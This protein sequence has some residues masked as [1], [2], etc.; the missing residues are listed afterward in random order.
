MLADEWEAADRTAMVGTAIVIAGNRG[1][2]VREQLLDLE[3]LTTSLAH[4]GAALHA[5]LPYTAGFVAFAQGRLAETRVLLHESADL[6]LANLPMSAP[7][8]A[9]AAIWE[10]NASGAREDLASLD[11]AGLHG[12]AV[13][14]DRM[15]IRAGIAALEGRTS[16]ALALYREALSAERELGLLWDEA[17]T[18]IDMATLLGSDLPEAAAAAAAARE[19]LVRL[20]ATPFIERLDAALAEERGRPE[21]KSRAELGGHDGH[22]IGDGTV[23]AGSGL[24]ISRHAKG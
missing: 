20:G 16:D 1:E 21:P 9:H 17:L 22:L 6:Y 7:A 2:E 13:E 23:E 19:I 12:P 24:Q 15:S 5:V 11:A 18:A 14:A 3:R 4:S 10:R 8:N